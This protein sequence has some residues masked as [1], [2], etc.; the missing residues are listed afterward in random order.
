MHCHICDGGLFHCTTCGGAE[1]S[2]TTECPG[3]KMTGD[4]L[5]EVYAGRLDFRG[6]AWVAPRGYAT[7]GGQAA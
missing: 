7:S 6:G 1:G 5:D 2:L 3:F 4:Q